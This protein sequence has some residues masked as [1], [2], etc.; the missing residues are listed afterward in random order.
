[1]S[2]TIKL[3][4]KFVPVIDGVYKKASLT[5]VLDAQTKD[6][7]GVGTVKVMKITTTGLGDYS[8]ENGYAKGNASLDWEAL[9][10]E[11]DRSAELSV[12]RMDNEQA[13]GQAFGAIMKEFIR[14]NVAPEVDAYRFAKYAK[15]S[16]AGT[17][18]A[19]LADGEAVVKAVR[20]ATTA[21][22][23]AEVPT[24]DRYLFITP[25]NKGLVDDLDTT[26]SKEVFKRFAGIIEVPQTRFYTDITMNSG[27]EAWGF[28][29]GAGAK[30][31]NFLAVSKSAVVQAAKMALPK[32]FDPDTNQ[33][34]DAWLFQYRLF[35]DAFAYENK[36]K[37]IY[38]H[39]KA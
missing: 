17:A 27:A 21:M 12:D 8:K 25:T 32:V 20:A 29:K 6:F 9:K 15:V 10:L 18:A 22:D 37:G 35:H 38:V 5:S 31:I 2:T 26:K 39:T 23:E 13:L 24:E 4:E 19:D 34:K 14:L 30:D 3:A 1:M 33:S 36:V 28:T 16:G 7:D 11:E